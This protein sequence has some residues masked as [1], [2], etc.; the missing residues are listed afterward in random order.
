M[1]I[2]SALIADTSNFS[3]KRISLRRLVKLT[4]TPTYQFSAMTPGTFGNAPGHS[5]YGNPYTSCTAVSTM[6]EVHLAEKFVTET[7]MDFDS[8][9][10]DG[11]DRVLAQSGEVTRVNS[12]QSS[13]SSS[14]RGRR[15]TRAE[16]DAVPHVEVPHVDCK[17]VLFEALE[18]VVK[19]V[20]AE[21]GG[22]QPP[23][24][25]DQRKTTKAAHPRTENDSS[26][27]EGIRRWLTEVE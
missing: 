26:L 8:T 2:C 22:R 6:T 14:R 17:G 15:D 4:P 9:L 10:I 18:A 25:G 20:A 19:D 1:D 24:E 7:I 11:V 23:K 21:R 12:A 13:R 3:I 27:K 5:R 16:S